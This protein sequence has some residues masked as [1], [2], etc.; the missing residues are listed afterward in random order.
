RKLAVG[1]G[2][3]CRALQKSLHLR[4]AP[5]LWPSYAPTAAPPT[6]SY[7]TLEARLG[8]RMGR[9]C[10][11]L[12]ASH[13]RDCDGSTPPCRASPRLF[14]WGGRFV[15]N[16]DRTQR[17]KNRYS[18]SPSARAS[19][20]W[21]F[22]GPPAPAQASCAPAPSTSRT[23]KQKGNG[24]VKTKANQRVRQHVRDGFTF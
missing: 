5:A 15:L 16:N 6:A 1:A 11:A 14:L 4:A 8:D 10:V 23:P 24:K 17:A 22:A 9:R 2:T 19:S 18:I 3:Q 13:N 7:S 20:S 12:K 21:E